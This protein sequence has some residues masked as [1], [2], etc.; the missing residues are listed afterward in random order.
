VKC[1]A[2]KRNG[3]AWA[4]FSAEGSE[5]RIYPLAGTSRDTYVPEARLGD[6]TYC[7]GAAA[8]AVIAASS[9]PSRTRSQILGQLRSQL[10]GYVLRYETTGIQDPIAANETIVKMDGR[11][12]HRRLT[13]W[14]GKNPSNDVGRTVREARFVHRGFQIDANRINARRGELY[15]NRLERWAADGVI[16]MIMSETAAAEAARGGPL[17]SLKAMSYVQSQTLATTDHEAGML[18]KIEA[19]IFPKGA[20]T[21]DKLRDVEIVF[22]ASKYSRTLVTKDGGSK[23]QPGGILGA[24]EMLAQLGITVMSDE[25]ACA[26]IEG[27]I[28]ARDDRARCEARETGARLPWWVGLD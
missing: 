20:D 21:I 6:K 24:R 13:D 22:N 2:W 26:H 15:M 4:A 11:E 9:S 5:V 7:R 8:G 16:E 18:K 12:W 27:L 28:A 10:E 23:R 14:W 3:A 17:Q 1:L 19:S 25:D